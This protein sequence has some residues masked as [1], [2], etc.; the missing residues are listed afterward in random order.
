MKQGML[1][2]F[3]YFFLHSKNLSR[4]QLKKRDELLSRDYHK[5]AKTK[6]KSVSRQESGKFEPDQESGSGGDQGKA[7]PAKRK[8]TNEKHRTGVA[9]RY[10]SCKNQQR[11]LIAFNQD[12]ILKYTCHL[13]DTKETIEQINKECEVDKYDFNKHVLL[14][15]QHYV[16]LKAQFEGLDSKMIALMDMYLL[17]TSGGQ[18]KRWS[19]NQI[20]ENWNDPNLRK[21]ALDNPGIIPIPG[22]NIAKI[23]K[24]NGYQLPNSFIDKITKKRIKKFGDLVVLFKC[25]FHIRRDNSLRSLIENIINDREIERY[26]SPDHFYDNIELFTDVDK[27][28]QAL[29]KI[30]GIC[31]ENNPDKTKKPI[32]EFS[33][34]NQKEYTYFTIHHRNT[35]YGKSLKNAL[36]R[37]GEKQADLIN[38]QINGLCDLFVEA[39]FGQNE[40]ARINLWDA[41]PIMKEERIDKVEGVKYI[42]R[43]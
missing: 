8:E 1:K 41:E 6:G 27:L 4:D 15:K 43:F 16:D 20:A 5:F 9:S 28:G 10:R 34:Y 14:I 24:N 31:V 21:W 33:F 40:Y 29:N 38:N 39:D 19:S 18:F 26:F 35:V 13:I 22:K 12:S 42:L 32:I 30:I 11:F 17:G 36:E 2:E 7:T 37:M 25:L 23:Q 3:L